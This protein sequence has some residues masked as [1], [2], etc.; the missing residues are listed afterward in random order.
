MPS[1][2]AT[3]AGS[4][5]SSSGNSK[6]HNARG[7]F[8]LFV[9]DDRSSFVFVPIEFLVCNLKEPLKPVLILTIRNKHNK[10]IMKYRN[11]WAFSFCLFSG[12]QLN[13][14][15]DNWLDKAELTWG[16]ARA[17]IAP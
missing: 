7:A 8:Q 16:P 6:L 15:L 10:K 12:N 3:H 14:Q 11:V 2:R 1:R 9:V 13:Q 4:W 17:I 5:Y